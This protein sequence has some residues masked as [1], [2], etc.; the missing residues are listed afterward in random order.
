MN[1]IASPNSRY[2][3]WL[4]QQFCNEVWQKFLDKKK[5]VSELENK[6]D[7]EGSKRTICRSETEQRFL[8]LSARIPA[9]TLTE[10]SRL[11]FNIMKV[12]LSLCLL[13]CMG[14]KLS[15]S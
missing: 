10:L 9:T 3:E 2:L 5:N 7:L 4:K 8:E 13:F 1:S 15:R 6:T 12:M 14:V 11:P